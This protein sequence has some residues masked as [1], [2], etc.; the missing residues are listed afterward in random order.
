M[1]TLPTAKQLHYLVVLSERLNF[2]HAA[3]ASCVTQSTLSAAVK[4][5]EELLGVRLVERDRQSVMMTP[6]GMEVVARARSILA[7]TKDLVGTASSHREP[8]TG[9]LRLGVIPTIAPFLLPRCLQAVRRKYPRLRLCLREDLTSALLTRLEQGELDFA[10]IAL[11]YDTGHFL[12]ERLIDDELWLIGRNEEPSLKARNV[13]LKADLLERLLLL[14]EGH[15]L[16]EHTLYSCAKATPGKVSGIEA[17]SLLT[18]IEMVQS[19]MGVALIPAMAIRHGVGRNPALAVRK[20]TRPCPHRTIALLARRSTAHIADFKIL[21]G[22][23]TESAKTGSLQSGSVS[24]DAGHIY[25]NNTRR[26]R[27]IVRG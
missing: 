6:L 2:T 18:L 24:E 11:P 20:M 19:G 4:E 23:I 5:L 12:V 13:E 1:T 3:A 9:S 22:M 10:L 17:T 15:C 16:R 26:S 14:E 21:A 25:R 7:A 8:M 27:P